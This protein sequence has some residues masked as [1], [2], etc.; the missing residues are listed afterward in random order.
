[1]SSN[2]SIAAQLC[3]GAFISLTHLAWFSLVAY[4][5]SSQTVGSL[6]ASM[7]HL[8]ERVIG[9]VLVTLGLGLAITS[10]KRA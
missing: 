8:I 6:V 2:T 1:M 9:G 7:R 4:V 10:A 3:F 5:F